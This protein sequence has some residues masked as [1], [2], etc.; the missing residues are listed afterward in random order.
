MIQIR[1]CRIED[2]NVLVDLFEAYRT[3]YK[4]HP[5]RSSAE[6]FLKER[7]NNRDS[8]IFVA[9]KKEEGIVGFVQLYPLFSSTRMKRLWLLNDLFVDPMQRGKGIS[10]KLIEQAKQLCIESGSCGM[11]LETAKS[12]LI[13]NQLYPSADFQ[14]DTDH[15]Y[16]FWTC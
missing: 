10:K 7:I 12:N 11:Q 13:G 6:N 15:N 8:V 3:F 16:Y 5:E 1:A 9:E 4:M 14:L 2:I